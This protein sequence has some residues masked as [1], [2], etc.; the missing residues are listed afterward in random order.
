LQLTVIENPRRT[1]TVQIAFENRVWSS[2]EI[3]S[4]PMQI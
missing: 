4:T 1:L 3:F 2:T